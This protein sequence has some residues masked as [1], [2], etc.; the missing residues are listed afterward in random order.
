MIQ[1]RKKFKKKNIDN[2]KSYEL[3][4]NAEKKMI[5]NEIES[6]KIYNEKL[7]IS[8]KVQTKDQLIDILEQIEKNIYDIE[9]E[10]I[11]LEKINTSFQGFKNT[12]LLM[13][14]YL[15]SNILNTQFIYD[16]LQRNHK[17][18]G[19]LGMDQ[20]VA[21]KEKHKLQ[22]EIDILYNNYHETEKALI[23]NS[24]NNKD[25]NNNENNDNVNDF[26]GVKR[27]SVKMKKKNTIY[28]LNERNDS[29]ANKND[30]FNWEKF[31]LP[32]SAQ[33]L[34]GKK[35][36]IKRLSN[37]SVSKIKRGN[38]SGVWSTNSTIIGDGRRIYPEDLYARELQKYN[39][40]QND[41]SKYFYSVF[42]Q[43]N[44]NHNMNHLNDEKNLIQ[45]VIMRN[46]PKTLSS[47]KVM[48]N[49]KSK[50]DKIIQKYKESSGDS[51]SNSMDE[52]KEVENAE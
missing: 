40:D 25:I 37:A 30:M 6:Y 34:V 3:E 16:I 26:F 42:F 46:Y 8:D 52:N 32:L 50:L 9:E 15:K 17:I 38:G 51:S 39:V 4:F 24:E 44:N 33:N 35:K 19:V 49:I 12:Q 27:N 31:F 18:Y 23:K 43:R 41:F 11:I 29:H 14:K 21:E 22:Q 28:I 13:I 5:L 45:N 48:K 2:Q 36:K 10:L 1:L 7:K 20:N 47:I